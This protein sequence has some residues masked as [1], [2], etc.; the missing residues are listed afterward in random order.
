METD[1]PKPVPPVKKHLTHKDF[2]RIRAMEL[3]GKGRWALRKC[4]DCDP[5]KDFLKAR[6]IG[7]TCLF[8]G[9]HYMSGYDITTTDGH[10]QWGTEFNAALGIHPPRKHKKA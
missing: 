10:P 8:C 3:K 6:T 5:A 4:W 1:R 2:A 9:H 7:F